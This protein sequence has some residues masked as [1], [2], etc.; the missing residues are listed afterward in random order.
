[1]GSN[2]MLFFEINSVGFILIIAWFHP[3]HFVRGRIFAS[4]LW[5]PVEASVFLSPK[6]GV[7]ARTHSPRVEGTPGK[8]G[9]PKKKVSKTKTFKCKKLA[10]VQTQRGRF[11]TPPPAC[12][13]FLRGSCRT[14]PPTQP[15]LSLWNRQGLHG[16]ESNTTLR[17]RRSRTN[18]FFSLICSL[19]YTVFVS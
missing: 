13:F 8:P 5:N 6:G 17:I 11:H 19:F 7:R 9:V 15:P 10:F 18:P 3:C 14:H 2:F 12:V 1:M 16:V 4:C